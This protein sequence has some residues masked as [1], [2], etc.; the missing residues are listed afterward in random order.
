MIGAGQSGHRSIS[1]SAVRF[2]GPDRKSSR[3][4]LSV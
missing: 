3:S 1:D 4:K 2:E